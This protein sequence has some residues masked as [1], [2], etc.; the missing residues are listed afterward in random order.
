MPNY[1]S[2]AARSRFSFAAVFALVVAVHDFFSILAFL[3]H[4]S[5]NEPGKKFFPNLALLSHANPYGVTY[6]GVMPI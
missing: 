6:E 1:H 2:A 3:N 5:R 4:Y